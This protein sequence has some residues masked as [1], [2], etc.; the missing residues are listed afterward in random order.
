MATGTSTREQLAAA[1]GLPATA[2][3]EEI[4]EALRKQMLEDDGD[5]ADE[6]ERR[7]M[8]ELINV[9]MTA[10]P[11]LSWHDAYQRVAA[12]HVVLAE[13]VGRGYRLSEFT[14]KAPS[15]PSTHRELLER[16]G[17]AEGAGGWTRSGVTGAV[18]LNA[19]DGSWAH[20]GDGGTTYGQGADVASLG[21]HMGKVLGGGQVPGY[22]PRSDHQD[23]G[24][25]DGSEEG[26]SSHGKITRTPA[27]I[28]DRQATETPAVERQLREITG[29]AGDPRLELH[30]CVVSTMTEK[31]LSYGAALNVVK[32]TATGK[33]LVEKVATFNA[34]L[35]G[36]P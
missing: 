22:P 3:P 11:T 26:P 8:A 23:K 32:Q 33:V 10:H 29:N 4:L 9:A 24:V 34:A 36:R 7:E 21:A 5:G 17:F 28:I 2:T 16:A 18:R 31:H 1:L 30:A 27:G 20:V 25:G 35:M 13:R 19:A 14:L 15:T 6:D 12:E